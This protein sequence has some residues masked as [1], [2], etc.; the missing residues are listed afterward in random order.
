MD[1]YN[2][3]S[4][5]GWTPFDSRDQNFYE[6][7]VGQE[8]GRNLPGGE[9][10][11]WLYGQNAGGFGRR[12]LF[13]QSLQSKLKSG[14]EA[15]QLSNGN[16]TFRDYLKGM[17]PNFVSNMWGRLTPEQRGE[18]SQRYAGPVRWMSRG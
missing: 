5:Y 3:N 8:L 17:S 13:G 12:D 15:A 14:Y 9:F 2:P 7:P 16:L 18:S 10:T 4:N 11:R 1:F 6:T